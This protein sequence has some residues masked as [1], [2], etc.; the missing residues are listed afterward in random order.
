[1][2]RRDRQRE[3]E[4]ED[5][6]TPPRLEILSPDYYD[7]VIFELGALASTITEIQFLSFKETFDH[8]LR[9]RDGRNFSPFTWEEFHQFVEGR[10]RTQA[11]AAFLESRQIPLPRGGPL[12]EADE[13]LRHDTDTVFGLAKIK[14]RA[15]QK[16]IESG[17]LELR[18]GAEELLQ[19]LVRAGIRTALVSPSKMAARV[20]DILKLRPYFD[21]IIDG[22]SLQEEGLLDDPNAD[23]FAE[24]LARL[25][26]TASA[27][28]VIEDAGPHLSRSRQQSFALTAIITG[29]DAQLQK[30]LLRRGA[31]LALNDLN[32]FQVRPGPPT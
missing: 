23:L 27:T 2:E 10:T 11:I 28:A 17:R 15:F 5:Q 18:T 1:M 3:L 9:T 30:D 24:A 31:D 4:Q 6:T 20:V 16:H 29:D 14:E 19:N 32:G 21:E 25:Q 12:P 13:A 8:L 26:V 22:E 7:A